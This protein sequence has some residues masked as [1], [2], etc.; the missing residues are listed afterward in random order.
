MFVS[1]HF[2]VCVHVLAKRVTSSTSEDH[3]DKNYVLSAGG[4]WTLRVTAV[5]EMPDGIQSGKSVK[6]REESSRSKGEKLMNPDAG[7]TWCEMDEMKGILQRRT[8]KVAEGEATRRLP[9]FIYLSGCR[10]ISLF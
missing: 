1:F 3:R 4:D 10:F 5:C 2:C 6:G 7:H 9:Q 8:E